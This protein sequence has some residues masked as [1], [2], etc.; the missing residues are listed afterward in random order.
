[1]YQD[2]GSGAAAP[3]KKGG[4]L[5]WGGIGCG[6][7]IV[8][9][10]IIAIGV[11]TQRAKIMGWAGEKMKAAILQALP[12][13]FDHVEATRVFEE[14][15]VA[16]EEDRIDEAAGQQ[17]G[18]KFQAAFQD[19][20]LS[21]EEAEELLDFMRETAGLD[22]KDDPYAEEDQQYEEEG[23]E[24]DATSEAVEEAAGDATE[25]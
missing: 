20:E 17:L 3:K 13:D 24:D 10:I 21:A 11:W 16:I 22:P 5:K 18:T 9:V 15:W 23:W 7:I 12:E 25:L 19:G 8:L 6:V 2:A 1:M 4:C 14:F